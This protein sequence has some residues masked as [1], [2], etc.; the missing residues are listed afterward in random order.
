MDPDLATENIKAGKTIF[1]IAGKTEVVDTTSGDAAAGEIMTG[2][3]AWVD[4]VE[5]TGSLQT[6]TLSDANDTVAAGNYAA[7]TLSIVDP[8][9]ATENI[10]AGKTLFGI[11]GKT[12]VVDT[13]SGDAIAGEVLTGKKAWVDGVEVT[14]SM[15]NVGTQNVTPTTTNVTITQGYHD[16]TGVVSGDADL[17]SGNIR[18]G[19]NIFGVAGNSN[20]VDSSSGTAA[21]ATV[22]F[23][24]K[25]WVDG[26][27]ILGYL[28]GG[29]ACDPASSFSPLQRWCDNGNGTVTDTKTGL[30]WLQNWGYF[31]RG[32]YYQRSVG[33]SN[34]TVGG[35]SPGTWRLPTR[36]EF[37]DICLNGDETL[38][39]GSSWKF[40]NVPSTNSA[41][42]IPWEDQDVRFWCCGPVDQVSGFPPD[43]NTWNLTDIMSDYQAC[44]SQCFTVAVMGARHP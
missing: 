12:E 9:L 31:S 21:T 30:I 13:T 6:Q 43:C 28:A 36:Q 20:V 44:A 10:K 42:V 37:K 40:T 18:A 32:T 25:A 26:R 4:G 29:V 35:V 8:D 3:K 14:G 39:I 33:V 38:A 23:G 5:I 15:A 22:Q 19:T 7:T 41:G 2:K 1:G 11:A 34:L 16:G 24:Q 27:E 17:V